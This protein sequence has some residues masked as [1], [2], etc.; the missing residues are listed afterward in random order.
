MVMRGEKKKDAKTE[1]EVDLGS[2]LL[3]KEWLSGM[4][5]A[6]GKTADSEDEGELADVVAASAPRPTRLGLGAKFVPHTAAIETGAAGK[7]SASIKSAKRRRE[8]EV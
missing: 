8:Q 1:L 2:S 4:Q 6:S 5:E 3:A 7:L